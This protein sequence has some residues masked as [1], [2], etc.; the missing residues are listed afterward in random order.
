MKMNTDCLFCKIV[1]GEIPAQ[2]VY[3]DKNTFVFMNL[4]PFERGQVL[5]VPKNHAV[6]LNDGSEED[7]T[8]LMTTVYRLAPK[9][10]KALGAT[11]YNLGMNHGVDAGQEIFHS[12][13]HWIPR[14]EGSERKFKKTEPGQEELA[15]V[16]E[17][18]R[19]G[20]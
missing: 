7:A 4:F 18:L 13:L 15:E 6:D 10:M 2:K 12:H 20:L 19:K 9:M 14:Y 1:A 16:A 3:E 11:A 8:A 5:L 17:I